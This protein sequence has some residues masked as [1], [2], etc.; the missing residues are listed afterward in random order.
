MR[1]AS[2]PRK[3]SDKNQNQQIKTI[4]F[5]TAAEEKAHLKRLG[6]LRGQI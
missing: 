1:R 3:E 5:K 2:G 4:L 6:Q